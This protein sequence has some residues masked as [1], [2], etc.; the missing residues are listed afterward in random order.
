MEGTS[1]ARRDY[2]PHEVTPIKLRPPDQYVRSNENMDTLS[3][4]KQDYNAYPINRVAPCL[5]QS[6]NYAS[7]EKMTTIPTYKGDYVAW[8]QP[9]RDM[10]KPDTS[11]HP[12]DAKFD[13]RTTVQ[14]AYPYQGPVVT[15]SC[16]P[17]QAPHISKIPL[18]DMTNYKLNYVHHPL[19]KRYVHEYQ[20]FKPS[21]VPFDGLTTHNLSYKGLMG[22]PAKSLKPPHKLP[23]HSCFVG[24]TEFQEKF[25]PWPVPPIF[26]RKRDVYVPPKNKMDLQTSTQIHYGNPHG[27]PATSCKP[28]A[29]VQ[30][31]TDPFDH[32]STMKDDYQPW[33]YA[34]PDAVFPRSS[35]TL[36]VEP[37]DTLTTFQTHYVPHP[38]SV[39]KSFRPR[40]PGPKAHIPFAQKTTYAISY[41][42]KKAVMCP[43][44]FKE[45]PGYVF[46]KVDEGGHRRFRPASVARSQC[47]SNSKMA[48]HRGSLSNG[49]IKQAGSKQLALGV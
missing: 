27:R 49:G 7:D 1:T 44:A 45:P 24:T 3:T 6:Q 36:P 41:T 39:T 25:Q 35:I 42:P 23:E 9:K 16:K 31:S 17:F 22:E 46:D 15:K 11:Y 32:R 34:K 48:D 2:I 33:Q 30:Q 40:L 13:H 47:P 18:E 29:R 26:S 28:L 5:P 20:P 19:A 21:D 38:L 37:M 14:D 12:P 10:I 4:Y 8:N 43:A